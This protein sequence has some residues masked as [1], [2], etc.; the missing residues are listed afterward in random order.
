MI[1]P[2]KP[3]SLHL[4]ATVEPPLTLSAEALI[5]LF[6]SVNVL[7]QVALEATIRQRAL[8][9]FVDQCRGDLFLTKKKSHQNRQLG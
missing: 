6:R 2:A 5:E 4:Y 8:I 7:L 1:N 3:A 9:S